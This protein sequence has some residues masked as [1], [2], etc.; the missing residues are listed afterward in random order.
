MGQETSTLPACRH[1]QLERIA[2]RV[3]A[4]IAA[5]GGAAHSN[6]G[7]VD[8]GGRTL[9][10]DALGT[11][12]AA[13]ELRDAAEQLTGRSV[14][15]V[16]NSHIDHDHWLGNQVFGSKVTII[17]THETRER[18]VNWGAEYVRQC[19]ENPAVLEN[20]IRAAERR[21]ETETD[22]R[23]RVSLS[24]RAI[25]L[26]NELETLPSLSLLF[27]NQTFER[28]VAFHGTDRMVEVHSFAGGHSHSDA[29]LLL[30]AERIIFAGDLCFFDSHFPLAGGDPK[31][32][33]GILEKLTG[34]DLETFVP[35]HGPLGAKA[36][37]V[38]QMR[39]IA[40]LHALVG[41][42]IEAGGSVDEAAGQPI[43]P[44]FDAWSRGM[45]LFEQNMRFL[46]RQLL[47]G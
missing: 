40:A 15:Y 46:Y 10:Y 33:M 14:A 27:P 19:R 4:A 12:Q 25:M 9:I 47:D 32:L 30:P 8:L 23:W 43:P 20:Q 28:K 11:P 34:L 37:V 18:M 36:D 29:V 17:A 1:F 38:L 16:I 5:W 45:G 7:I 39:Y 41:R 3:Y 2:S 44:P 6:A 22:E 24:G 21:L 31:A 13:E 26:R 42:I 35:G